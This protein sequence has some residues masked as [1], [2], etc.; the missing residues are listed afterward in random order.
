MALRELVPWRWG[1]LARQ[2]EREETPLASLHGEIDRLFEDFWRGFGGPLTSPESRWQL[3]EA[4]PRIDETEDEEGYHI[5]A[6]LPGLEEKDVE[7]TL[8][9][10]VLTIRGEK[11]E[12]AEETKKDY[13]RR[14]RT[15]GAFRRSLTVPSEVDAE[16]ITA[17]MKNGVLAV[18]L[19]KRPE[20][21]KK[22]K[23]IAI[24]T[25]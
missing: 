8:A 25:K 21:K 17:K 5:T 15:F 11:K 23:R 1:A 13:F 4:L 16:R 9:E 20:A 14:E 18:D 6:E 24:E 3:G 22:A 19:P 10:G 7:V 2:R 12:E